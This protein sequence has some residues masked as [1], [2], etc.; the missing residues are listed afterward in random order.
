MNRTMFALMSTGLILFAGLEGCN[1]KPQWE[2]FQGGTHLVLTVASVGDLT[3]DASNTSRIGKLVK[4]RINELGA[5]SIV[6]TRS[7][8]NEIIVQTPPLRKPDMF[9]ELLVRQAMLKFQLVDGDDNAKPSPKDVPG[10]DE[11][12]RFRSRN[13]E[14]GLITATTIRVKKQALLTGES[15][16]DVQIR[17]DGDRNEPYVFV[18]FDKKGAKILEK[19]TEENIGKRL[20]IVLDETVYNAPVIREKIAGG[21]ASIT[22]AFTRDEAKDLLIVLRAGGYPVPVRLTECK[23][24]SRQIWLGD[25]TTNLR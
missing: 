7:D 11:V 22:G 6:Q 18:E 12:L 10:E 21:N 20:A 2:E 24:L 25:T 13:L 4:D 14:T 1:T 5:K 19:I 23:T 17:T 9:I 8:R 3:K 15:I 16:S